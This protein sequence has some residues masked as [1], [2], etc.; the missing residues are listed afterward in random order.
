LKKTKETIQVSSSEEGSS[1]SED[2]KKKSPKSKKSGKSEDSD[3]G[4]SPKSKKNGEE[5]KSPNSSKKSGED[6]DTGKSPKSKKKSSSADSPKSPKKTKNPNFVKEGFLEKKGVIR[7]NWTRRWMVLVKN[8]EIRYYKNPQDP[9]PKGVIP[10][11]NASLYTHVEKK[12]AEMVGYLNL[13]VGNRD[14]LLRA[15][16]DDDK[17]EWVKAIKA[18]IV[19]DESESSKKLTKQSSFLGVVKG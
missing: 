14:F 3:T 4:K 12:Q 2:E 18:N 1:S 11:L 19:L 15:A 7:H 8:K 13:R 9:E 10:L 16:D 17:L 5:E 6:S